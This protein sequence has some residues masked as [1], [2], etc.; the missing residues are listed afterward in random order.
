VLG[1]AGCTFVTPVATMN[2]Y[3]PSD[4]VSA[5]VGDVQVRNIFVVSSKGV[6]GN[7]V[8]AFINTSDS[9]KR[10]VL[11][12]QAKGGVAEHE[13]F[14]LKAGQIRSLGNP[15][16]KQIV[17]EKTGV[18]PGALLDLFIQTGTST[19]KKIKVPVLDGSQSAY[20]TLKP[21][22]KPKP[23]ATQTPTSTPTPTP[24]ATN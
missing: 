7:L 2:H 12:Y 3:D 10:V 21:T 6:N 18:K 9:A 20:S 17:L 13:V 19:G 22:P 4:G 14:V 15:G 11:E 16:V 5:N 24:T 8:G 23:T 1:T